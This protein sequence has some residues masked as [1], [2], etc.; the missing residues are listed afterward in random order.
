MVYGISWGDRQVLLDVMHKNLRDNSKVLVNKR[1]VD[2]KH[3][4]D[5]VTVTC[6]DKSSYKGDV[7]IGA[8]GV[9]S[10]TRVAMW[11]LAEK[12]LPK[13]VKADRTGEPP[14]AR[15]SVAGEAA[16][17]LLTHGNLAL[18]AKFK[19]LFGIATVP[20]SPLTPGDMDVIWDEGM[21]GSTFA[22]PDGKIWFFAGE[23]LDAQ[24]GI[25][26]IPQF[27]A[28]DEEEFVKRLG[29]M[30]F[31]PGFTLADIWKYKSSSRLVPVEEAIYKVWTWGRIALIGDSIHKSTPDLGAGGN[32]AVESAAS[33]ANHLKAMLDE[34]NGK[35]PT[36]AQ[37]QA[38]LQKYVKERSYRARF[39]VEQSGEL[40]RV[41]LKQTFADKLFVDYGLAHLTEYLQDMLSEMSVGATKLNFL[42]LP[43]RSLRGT[44]PWNPEQGLGKAE[45]KWKR[46]FWALPLIAFAVASAIIMKV[47]PA[48]PM[49]EKVLAG[50]I[51]PELSTK[52]PIIK[53]FYGI[54]WLD[55]L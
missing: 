47:D 36:E 5:G 20:G 27:T 23:P 12:D 49:A 3:A 45:S 15:L 52:V 48:I 11:D 31:R 40:S 13:E 41:H 7:L 17:L 2:V 51:V 28:D 37:I 44:L 39:V 26:D 10:R 32:A 25:D 43:E 53:S 1:V 50:G 19:T 8:D 14:P 54:K 9:Y 42:P 6:D 24:Y 29:H 55:D 38:A 33:V 4:K 16:K 30:T 34:C 46:A 35:R 18:R 22:G 21:G